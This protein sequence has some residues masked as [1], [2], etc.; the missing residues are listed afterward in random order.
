MFAGLLGHEIERYERRVRYGVVKVPHDFRN[1]IDVFFG[2]HDLHDVLHADCLSRLGG[3]IDLGIALAFEAGGKGEQVRV[4]TLGQRRNGGRVDA[5][6]EERS[7]GHIGP[8]ML[9]DAVL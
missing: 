4:M 1:R 3:N 7:D 8:H 6:R 9:F 2:R 5:A